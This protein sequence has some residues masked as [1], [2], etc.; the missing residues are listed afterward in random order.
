MLI[1][2]NESEAP[3]IIPAQKKEMISVTKVGDKTLVR[4]NASSL[5]VIQECLRKAK[6]S[7]FEEWKAETE[8]PATVFGSAIHHAME[9][10]YTG[11][12]R[13]RVMPSLETLE[14]MAYGHKV[15]N[16]E[17][18]LI[19]RAVRGF[20]TKAELLSAL[21]ETDKRSIYNGVWILHNYFKKYFEDPYVAYV[22]KDGPFIERRFTLRLF[23]DNEIIIDIFGQ[24]D[25][26]FRHSVTGQIIPG[27]HKTT[28]GLN[29][30][31]SSYFDKEK[32]NSQYTCYVLG[33]REVFGLDVNEFF[34]NIIEVKAK[35]KTSRGQGPSF[36]RQPTVRTQDDFD[37][38]REVVTHSVR[39]Y[40]HAIKTG[41]WP[42]GPLSAC[43]SYGSCQYREVCA[44]PK[45][46]RENILSAK[47]KKG[48]SDAV[49]K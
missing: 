45:S 44:A 11:A 38:F 33:A 49:V 24:I 39:Q 26:A 48:V 42:I 6:Y 47:F 7:L 17:T 36:P 14:L 1:D 31:G 16:E 2:L 32:P 35:P 19:L 20:I 46:M 30:N 8:H 29:F 41:V 28:A 18:D 5:S 15:E 4:I 25:F 21:P 43:N 9:I 23:E 40:L 37:E 27:D 3:L 22:D 34:V 12:I 13:E 10:Y